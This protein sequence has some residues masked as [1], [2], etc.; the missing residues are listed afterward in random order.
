MIS[1]PVAMARTLQ[2][3]ARNADS[4]GVTLRIAFAALCCALAAHAVLTLVP[5]VETLERSVYFAIDAGAI[6]LIVARAVTNP[7]N[8]AGWGLVAVAVSFG[9]SGDLFRM[10]G[11]PRVADA[12]FLSMF[13]T[14]C[15]ALAMLARDRIRPFPAWLAIDGVLAGLTLAAL[16]SAAFGPIQSLT[17]GDAATVASALVNFVC[18]LLLLVVVLVAFAAT[19]W[20]PGR[21]W[22]LIGAGLA[23]CT[24]TDGIFIF[25]QDGAWLSNGW[26]L[27]IVCPA[28]AAWQRSAAP[29]RAHVGWTMATIPLGGSA[30]SI[31]TLL[32]AGLTHDKPLTLL[33]A[34]AALFAALARA[35]VMLAENFRLLHRARQPALTDKLTD[36]PNR[37]ALVYDLDRA[38]ES[39][40]PH[41]LVFFDLDGF[42]DYNDAFGHPAGDALLCRLAPA[43]ASV[44]RSY[45]LGGDEFCLLVPGALTDHD[46][47]VLDAV[48][49][50]SEHGDG[51]SIGAS[52]GLVAL[53]EDAHDATEALRLADERMYARKRRR[54]G[55]ARGQAR[56]LLV[57]VMAEREPDLDEHNSSVAELATAVGRELRL[58]TEALDV[59]VRAA[60]LHDVGKVAVPDG[61]LHKPGPLDEREWAVMRQH[62]VAGE[63]ILGASESMRP[64]ARVVRA[65][66]ERYDGSGYPDGLKGEEIPLEARIVTACD[67]YDAMLS[68]R[69]YKEPM[70]SDEALAEL[71][72]CAGTQFDPLVVATLTQLCQGFA[73]LATS[74]R[75][76]D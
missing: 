67:A 73:T 4:R 68:R 39:R 45:R 24:L 26:I 49:A 61:I 7:R 74:G 16:A 22:W 70:R 72:R 52:Y 27:A 15:A 17:G 47:L 58:E 54:R 37:R 6:A 59:L 23:I 38:C 36:L 53:P 75:A 55:S 10:A 40:E 60:E 57:K 63:R 12:L 19:D 8:R 66:H 65:S 56:D 32:F 21:A 50:L 29:T 35:A 3:R 44:G 76:D 14:S 34:T 2:A 30:L 71:R 25:H 41:T 5:G 20:R 28:V 9:V 64:V 31:T 13:L 48:D 43:L 1:A 33:L 69:A 11:H 18:D 42:K 62:T 51:F 46:P